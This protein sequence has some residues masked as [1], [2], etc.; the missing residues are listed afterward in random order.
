MT[1]TSCPHCASLEAALE[2]VRAELEVEKAK[3]RIHEGI[4]VDLEMM[5]RRATVALDAHVGVRSEDRP[6]R[7]VLD[8]PKTE[9]PPA[10]PQET[11]TP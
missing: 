11:A 7:P 2:A 1:G 4:L 8:N 5:G 10:M 3:V 6:T 9:P